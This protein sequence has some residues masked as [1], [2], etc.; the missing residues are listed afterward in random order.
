T[1]S[2]PAKA[3]PVLLATQAPHVAAQLDAPALA[4][5]GEESLEGLFGA[6]ALAAAN[7]NTAAASPNGRQGDAQGAAAR[8]K[9]AN[10]W[11][12]WVLTLAVV[13]AGAAWIKSCTQSDTADTENAKPAEQQQ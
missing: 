10:G 7:A 1:E 2:T 9:P 11:F 4:A 3:L 12:K 5:L 13:L 6:D 8:D